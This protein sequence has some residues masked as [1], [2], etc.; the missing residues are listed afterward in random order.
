MKDTEK[1]E[2]LRKAITDS[3]GLS[4]DIA[5]KLRCTRDVVDEFQVRARGIRCDLAALD[6][7]EH[8]E[9][10]AF[11]EAFQA[12][13]DA[14]A[15]TCVGSSLNVSDVRSAGLALWNSMADAAAE[16]FRSDLALGAT[17]ISHTAIRDILALKTKPGDA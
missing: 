15:P 8:V 6:E 16:L 7:P 17:S 13:F 3:L 1:I 2:V 4:H 10:S 5:D 12:W 11:E 14:Y 9:V